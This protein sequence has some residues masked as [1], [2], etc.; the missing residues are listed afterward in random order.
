MA[1]DIQSEI[2]KFPVDLVTFTEEILNDLRASALIVA[3]M[4]WDKSQNTVYIN[5]K[6]TKH[7]A[8]SLF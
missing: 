2:R 3:Y 7:F 5:S 1:K 6:S 4:K 8:A